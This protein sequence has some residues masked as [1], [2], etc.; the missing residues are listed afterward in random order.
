MIWYWKTK[1]KITKYFC[2]YLVYCKYIYFFYIYI[3]ENACLFLDGPWGYGRGGWWG[4][5]WWGQGARPTRAWGR[6][7]S[8]DPGLE[9]H[10]GRHN[11]ARRR[12]YQ[13]YYA[14]EQ[15]QGRC[16]QVGLRLIKIL[17][18]IRKGRKEIKGSFAFPYCGGGV[19]VMCI[20]SILYHEFKKNYL[21]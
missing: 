7:S 13:K 20:Y 2:F 16:P 18:K 5:W 12:D 8:P 17:K 11:R 21:L 10:G 3:I 4:A 15:S 1:Y 14:G 19:R 9:R 6:L